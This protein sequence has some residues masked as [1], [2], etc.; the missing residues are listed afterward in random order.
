MGN[1]TENQA[2]KDFYVAVI[3]MES[4]STNPDD[5]PLYEESFFLV[6][7]KSEDI[8]FQKAYQ[9]GISQEC[10][11]LN[12]EKYLIRWKLSKVIDVNPVLME[13]LE[14]PT[15]LYARYFRDIDAYAKMEILYK[16]E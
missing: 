16:Q 9:Y 5:G 4:H 11:Y 7:A 12:E 1:D 3:L 6:K 2:L 14:D 8:A 13:S 15:E 10:E